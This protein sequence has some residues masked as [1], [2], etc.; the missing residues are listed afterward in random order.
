MKEVRPCAVCGKMT[1]NLL[2][3]DKMLDIPICSKRCEYAYLNNLTPDVKEQTSIVGYLDKKITQ[4]KM[5]NK[6]GWSISGIG[7]VVVIIS[8]VVADA[9][10]FIAGNFTVIFGTLSTRYLENKIDKL[11]K[12]RKRIVI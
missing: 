5:Y 2:F 8:F 12:M 3:K 11:T 6:I 9:M 7:L 4:T 10:L 1:I